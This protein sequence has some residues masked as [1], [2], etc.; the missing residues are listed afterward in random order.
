MNRTVPSKALFY[1]G[2]FY[3]ALLHFF[4]K[5]RMLA[6]PFLKAALPPEQGAASYPNK[7]QR[8]SKGNPKEGLLRSVSLIKYA[9]K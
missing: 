9:A 3:N 7:I 4:A 8:K 2:L 1:K 5:K 6:P